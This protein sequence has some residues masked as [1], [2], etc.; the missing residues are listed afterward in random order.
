MQL[1]SDAEENQI[2]GSSVHIVHMHASGSSCN[3]KACSNA[4]RLRILGLVVKHTRQIN[5]DDTSANRVR[6]AQGISNFLPSTKPA[7][8]R[9]SMSEPPAESLWGAYSARNPPPPPTPTPMIGEGRY[10]AE[11]GGGYNPT[12]NGTLL[13]LRRTCEQVSNLR[14][15]PH[16]GQERPPQSC[17]IWGHF[18]TAHPTIRATRSPSLIT[19]WSAWHCVGPM[20]PSEHQPS[21]GG[22]DEIHKQVLE[23]PSQDGI[24]NERSLER[25]MV[26]STWRSHQLQPMALYF[27]RVGWGRRG[28][29]GGRWEG[30]RCPD[31]AGGGEGA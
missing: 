1:G 22:R 24:K 27:R 14:L 18:Y 2:F 6:T 20:A 28:G 19:L 31:Y 23:M 30:R 4:Y 15:H 16:K 21:E 17:L 5:I 9:I 10:G 29:G 11:G 25:P 3:H 7:I 26:N 12:A 8:P 13:G